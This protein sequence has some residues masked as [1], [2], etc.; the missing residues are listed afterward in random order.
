M[1]GAFDGLNNKILDGNG[2]EVAEWVATGSAVNHPKLTNAATGGRPKIEAAGDDTNISLELAAKGTG[3]VIAQANVAD[4]NVIG[5]L[6]VLHRI[7]VAAGA[8]GDVDVVLTH[9]TRVIDV[10]LVKKNGAG[11]GAGSITVKNGSSAIT[12]A[13]SIDVADQT[14][15]R[16]GTIDDAQWEIAASGTLKITR[17]RSASSDE[18]CTVYVHGI[19]VA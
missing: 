18:T 19:R 4:A 3:T 8:T 6:P 5:A 15:V 14:V 13:M 16:A 7:D 9:K 10:H 17:T 1:A 11:G 2:N 12:N